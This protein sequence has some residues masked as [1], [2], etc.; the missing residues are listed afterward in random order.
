MISCTF[1]CYLYVTYYINQVQGDTTRF[2]S[3]LYHLVPSCIFKPCLGHPRCPIRHSTLLF[4]FRQND[5]GT[6]LAAEICTTILGKGWLLELYDIRYIYI[7]CN[8]VILW[9]PQAVMF[10]FP[11]K[12]EHFWTC[13]ENWFTHVKPTSY[14][15]CVACAHVV[16]SQKILQNQQ[17]N[18]GLRFISLSSGSTDVGRESNQEVIAVVVC[19]FG[20]SRIKMAEAMFWSSSFR[21]VAEIVQAW[22]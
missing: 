13:V 3:V 5:F 18:L 14:I 4:F 17:N 7:L 16:C 20:L 12:C 1:I 10:F 2:Q 19:L 15:A 9:I 6:P 22:R 21:N 8:Y 11:G